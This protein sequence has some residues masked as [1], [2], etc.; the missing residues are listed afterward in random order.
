MDLKI[1]K[2]SLKDVKFIFNV[3]NDSL[4][5]K[6]SNNKKDISFLDHKKWFKS[7]INSS[8]NFFY[9]IFLN[10]KTKEQISYIRFEGEIFY[11]KVSIG[12]IKKFRKKNLSYQILSL[13]EQQ[14][15]KNI[16]LLAEV[17][18][19]NAAS[20]KLFHKLNY[21]LLY[22]SSTSNFYCKI[23]EQNKKVD[24]YLK[25]INEIEK[26]RKNNNVNWMDILRIAFK[27][28]PKETSN[29][30]KKISFSDQIINKLSKNLK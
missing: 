9:I 18:K 24:N 12:I 20:K 25:V 3:R 15:K 2:A 13:A 5:K 7:K 21:I 19:N 11:H 10:N 22:K 1:R 8:K 4:S 23:L 6:N 27:N 14:I 26:V 30:F 29:V 28:S 17:K 16:L